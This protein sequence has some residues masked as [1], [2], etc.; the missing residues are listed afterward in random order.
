MPQKKYDYATMQH[1]YVTTDI[2]LRELAAK[3]GVKS[4]SSV[5]AQQRRHGWDNLRARFK[6][7]ENERTAEAVANQRAQ[8]IAQVEA[9]FLDVVHATILKMG[10]DLND[11]WVTDEK[12]GQR[13]FIQGQRVSPEGLTKLIDKFLVMTGNVTNREAHLGISLPLTPDG[14]P[15][16]ILRELRKLALEKGAGAEP[17]GQSPLPGISGAKQVN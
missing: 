12:S 14:I 13:K 9:D 6:A 2:S 4:A 8:K 17:M 10:V 7:L 16:D 11:Q 15:P 3:H 5:S 1:E